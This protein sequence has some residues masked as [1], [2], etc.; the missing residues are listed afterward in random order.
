MGRKLFVAL[1]ALCEAQEQAHDVARPMSY[2]F[3][4]Q[5]LL[6]NCTTLC[7]IILAICTS[8]RSEQQPL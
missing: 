5:H 8:Q 2:A 4:G 6:H 1:R 3:E 7:H